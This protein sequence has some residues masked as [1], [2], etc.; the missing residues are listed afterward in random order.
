MPWA[1]GMKGNKRYHREEWLKEQFRTKTTEEIAEEC[2]VAKATI[3]NY[4]AKFDFHAQKLKGRE[5]VRDRVN[6]HFECDLEDFTSSVDGCYLI[7]VLFGDGS[8][9]KTSER[10]KGEYRGFQ[11]TS[12]DEEFI[13]LV[14]E[15]FQNVLGIRLQRYDDH[16]YIKAMCSKSSVGRSLNKL[17]WKS[18]SWRIPEVIKKADY[19]RKL[20]F[21]QGFMDS[22]GSVF[23]RDKKD[24][25]YYS[26]RTEIVNEKG[27]MDLK[28]LLDSCDFK[29]STFGPYEA[30][31]LGKKDVFVLMI[32]RFSDSK[33]DLFRMKRKSDL[34]E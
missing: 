12:A 9:C 10:G 24:E 23:K 28:D 25:E 4:S 7:G 3:R 27:L 18:V 13:E 16:G 14:E 32:S 33:S 21:I 19:D 29:S 6:N 31:G 11:I 15:A 8:L 1:N 5:K 2:G 22:D 20:A 17:D 26:A 34:L 30:S